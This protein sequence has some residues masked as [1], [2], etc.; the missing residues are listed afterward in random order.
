MSVI[1]SRH[2]AVEIVS[3]LD[4]SPNLAIHTYVAESDDKAL[5]IQGTAWSDHLAWDF[6][7]SHH[8]KRRR[9][10]RRLQH[11]LYGSTGRPGRVLPVLRAFYPMRHVF[12]DLGSL[13]W[14]VASGRRRH[15]PCPTAS[16]GHSRRSAKVVDPIDYWC[17]E[18][19]GRG[20]RG[21]IAPV[22]IKLLEKEADRWTHFVFTE[23]HFAEIT[24][25][26]ETLQV[27]RVIIEE[28]KQDI[29]QVLVATVAMCF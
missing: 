17:S 24:R 5:I 27:W 7:R 23:D 25:F 6:S 14:P 28:L 8:G 21:R 29:T 2:L 22:V 12:V 16:I 4:L 13:M 15:W 9:Y 18:P 1:L 3:F 19:W 10:E 20:G 11:S 26:R